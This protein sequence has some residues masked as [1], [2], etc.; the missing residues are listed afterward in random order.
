MGASL[1]PSVCVVVR[2]RASSTWTS[3]GLPLPSSLRARDL[4][5][6]RAPPCPDAGRGLVET[7]RTATVTTEPAKTEPARTETERTE[8]AKTVEPPVDY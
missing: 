7:T 4:V 5:C 2:A 8:P 6:R 3:T 1:S